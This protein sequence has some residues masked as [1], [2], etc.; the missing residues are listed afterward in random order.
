MGSR[1]QVWKSAPVPGQ[2]SCLQERYLRVGKVDT[3]VES[4]GQAPRKGDHSGSPEAIP[5]DPYGVAQSGLQGGEP[6][7]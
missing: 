7:P 5:V 1:V 6:Q 4:V 2:F 3:V